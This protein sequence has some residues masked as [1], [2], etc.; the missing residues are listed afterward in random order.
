MK[1]TMSWLFIAIFGTIGAVM[2]SAVCRIAYKA[3]GNG[4]L[5]DFYN[6]GSLIFIILAFLLLIGSIIGMAL[7]R[8]SQTDI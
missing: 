3:D 2:T 1:N 6:M 4:M 7:S 8:K 5:S